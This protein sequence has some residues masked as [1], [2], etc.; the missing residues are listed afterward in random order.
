[1]AAQT[2]EKTQNKTENKYVADAQGRFG[3][4]FGGRFV[5]ETIIPALD[6]LTAAYEKAKADP[7]FQTE[8]DYYA[9]NYV[10]RPTPLFFAEKM[11]QELGGAQIYLKREDLAHTGAHKINNA[12]GQILLARRMNKPRIIAETGAGQH[13]VATAT[14][15]ALFGYECIVYMGE[16]DVQRQA[17]NVVRMKLLGA[18]VRPVSSGTKTLKDALN[19]AMRDWVTNVRDTHYII[20][21]VAGPHPYPTMVRDF[22]SVIGIEARQQ[23]IGRHG[24][25]ARCRCRLCR[26]R[27]Q[28]DGHFL[29][30][31][32]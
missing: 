17:L 31:C 10:G 21:T 27:V 23:I 25:P 15:C 2:L 19:E 5:P 3:G 7:A 18:T 20:G 14:A 6:E 9:K 8:F 24:R 29:P 4:E 22:Q 16:E 11:T 1:M 32:P 13:G 12:L 28:C 30:V 26:R